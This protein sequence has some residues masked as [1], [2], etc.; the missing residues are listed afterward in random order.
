[1]MINLQ[2]P[3]TETIRE[4]WKVTH[5]GHVLFENDACLFYPSVLFKQHSVVKTCYNL[6]KKNSEVLWKLVLL[7]FQE[8]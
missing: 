6:K 4:R 2:I 1:M 7:V 3:K 8:S 5:H